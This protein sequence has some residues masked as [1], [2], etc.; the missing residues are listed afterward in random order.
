M[1]TLGSPRNG[2]SLVEVLLAITLLGLILAAAVG[3]LSASQR[4]STSGEALI[5][6]TSQL[7][8]THQFVRRQLSQAQTLVIEMDFDENPVRFVGDRNEVTFVAPMP[9]YLSY[10]GPYVQRFR[11]EPGRQGTELVFYFAML[12]GYEE[13]EIDRGEGVVLIE[14]L[15][16]GQ[17]WFLDE[18]LEEAD[19]PFWTPEWEDVT[20]V[21]LAIELEINMDRANGLAWPNLITPVHLDSEVIRRREIR[22]GADLLDRPER[23][24]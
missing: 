19:Q 6:E 5:Q 20:R 24:R 11:L 12:N 3:G 15:R 18:D 7:R 21:P 9:G 10:G 14:N 13:G 17:F 23:R 2:F 16:Q 22:S 8:L 4:A 1:T